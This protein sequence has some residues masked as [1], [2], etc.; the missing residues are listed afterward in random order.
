MHDH[1]STHTQK[2]GSAIRPIISTVLRIIW[3][4]GLTIIVPFFVIPNFKELFD[5]YGISLPAMSQFVIAMG[6]TI[7]KYFIVYAIAAVPA[8][9]AWPALLLL[10]RKGRVVSKLIIADWLLL[11]SISLFLIVALGLPL[12]SIAAGITAQS[13]H[14]QRQN[15]NAIEP[16]TS[17]MVANGRCGTH[18]NMHIRQYDK[19]KPENISDSFNVLC[20][21]TNRKLLMPF[22]A[23]S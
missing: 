7:T 13:K 17:P 22:L 12:I 19:T 23:S 1:K 21:S 15:T 10:F 5:E 18:H 16:R 11:L 14:L 8:V 4:L 2:T 3:W 6:D 20:S 9:V